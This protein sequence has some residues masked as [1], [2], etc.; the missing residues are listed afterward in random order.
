MKL[1]N[2]LTIR[3]SG[4][5]ILI[6]SVWSVFY[7]I[8]Q[9]NEIHDGIDEGLNN[10]KQ[11]F[12]LKAND[13]PEFV[14]NMEKY[15]PLNMIV[16]HISYEDAIN[17]KETY[18]TTK[19]YFPSE[20]E[21]EEVRM[22]TTVFRCE[23]DGQYYQLKFFTST[24]ESDDLVKSILYLLII[25]WLALALALIFANKA[26]I[27]KSSRPFRKLLSNLRGFELNN[28][29][30]IDFPD[31]SIDEYKELNIA[32][33][34]LLEENIQTF[35]EQKNFIENASHELQTPLAIS[36]NKLDLLINDKELERK[37]IEEISSILNNLNRMKKL[38]STLLLLS[39]IKNKQ[40]SNNE[41]L[42]LYRIFEETLENFEALIEHKE[43]K[44]S[45]NDTGHPIVMMNSDLAYIMATNLIKNAIAYNIKGG[46]I[47][48]AFTPDSIT[49]K[50][51]GMAPEDEVN[52]FDRYVSHSEN[53]QSSGLGLSIVQSIVKLFGYKIAYQY[54]KQHIITIDLNK[55]Q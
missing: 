29:K 8:F 28:T 25:L 22:L 38:N 41:Q 1:V 14:I 17:S 15:N 34:K 48:L 42:D 24:V 43:L 11:E 23:Q 32:V 49:I 33:K 6:L 52:I 5:F 53:K 44:L 27:D 55:T 39:K 3:L 45:I 21:Y 18:S 31:T 35:T 12:I 19:V 50:N 9:M 16:N 13:S 51:D 46:N 47:T 37:Q 4:I 36:I 7:F 30:M 54:N 10:L 40:F 26:I 2:H 20:E